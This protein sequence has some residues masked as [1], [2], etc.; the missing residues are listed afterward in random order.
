[1]PA[2]AQSPFRSYTSEGSIFIYIYPY[3]YKV[4]VKPTNCT[5]ESAIKC[6]TKHTSYQMTIPMCFG[7]KGPSSGNLS[8]A[9]FVSPTSKM[10]A[11]RPQFYR[12]I[13]KF[14]V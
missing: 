3:I 13:K 14:D 12:T 11:F 10:C 7:T 9:N 2:F 1:M 6:I 4:F 5:N 8:T